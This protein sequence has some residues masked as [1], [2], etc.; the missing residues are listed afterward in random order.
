MFKKLGGLNIKDFK[1]IDLFSGIGAF[2]LAMS[3][4]GGECVFAAE[5]DDAA[6]EVYKE[7][8]NI[9]SKNNVC[10]I[11]PEDIP[12]H[13]VLCAGF[14]CQ[15]FSNAGNKK[16][17]NDT[18]GTLFFEIERILQYHKT[19]FIILE[20]VK[21]LV[22]HD[23]GNTYNVIKEHLNNL[24]YIL[25]ETP[26][27]ISPHHI[28]IPQNRERIFILGIHKDY[29][30]EKF[31]K[32]SLPKTFPKTSMYD[33]LD[34]N[35]NDERYKISKYEEKCFVA[36]DEFLKY[37]KLNDIKMCS[38]VLVDEFGQNYDISDLQDWKQSYCKRNRELYLKNK[39]FIDKWM[40]KYNVKD[41]KKRDRKFEWQA[42]DTANTVFDT[43]IQLR[44]SG[45]RCKKTS[46]FPALVAIVQTS[47]VAKYKRRITPRE[48]ARLQSFPDTFKLHNDDAKAYKQLGNSA[49]V[50]VI[51][52]LAKQLFK[53]GDANN[54]EI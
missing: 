29:F 11:N 20:N 9:D 41:F 15:P 53:I 5:I 23:N 37:F 42:G 19:K 14:P 35:I 44:Q 33:I 51:K 21:H 4:L 22:T 25:T 40:I 45:I 38:P 18:R 49:N 46:T 26:T 43:L 17:F 32:I 1:F 54:T 2:H 3:D 16:G 7:N 27:I 48:A 39:E 52:Y 28:G 34:E 30:N 24:G 8:F 10:K 36:W 47:I 50:E 31:I 12:K 13:D 6:I